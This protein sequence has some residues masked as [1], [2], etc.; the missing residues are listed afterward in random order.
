MMSGLNSSDLEIDLLTNPEKVRSA[1]DMPANMSSSGGGSSYGPTVIAESVDH[2][3]L[4]PPSV[5]ASSSSHHKRALSRVSEEDSSSDSQSSRSRRSRPRRPRSPAYSSA[6]S[7]SSSGAD[8][9]CS[10]GNTTEDDGDHV[11]VRGATVSN[12]AAAGV[13]LGGSS[14][15]KMTPEEVEA[16]KR[17]LLFALYRFQMKNNVQLPRELTLN[18]SLEE[19][20]LAVDFCRREAKLSQAV[21]LSK[22]VLVTVCSGLEFLNEKY[23][24]FDVYL[25]GWSET[26]KENEDEYDDVFEELFEKY[27]DKVA[28]SPEIKLMM[29]V[30]GSAAGYHLMYKG[31]K[32]LSTSGMAQAL[33]TMSGPKNDPPV[34]L[35]Q[36]PPPNARME[37]SMMNAALPPLPPRT[38]APVAQTPMGTM[39]AMGVAGGANGFGRNLAGAASIR[40]GRPPM[41]AP[42]S[43][44]DLLQE[45]QAE[46]MMDAP[47]SPPIAM[48]YSPQMGGSVMSVEL[49]PSAPSGRGRGRGGGA[50]R[51]RA[52]KTSVV[53]E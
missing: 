51:G 30:V 43:I 42:M 53:I 47:A 35:P 12:A 23:D 18:S 19:I 5:R 44:E 29:M 17:K 27:Q 37:P 26:V 20:Q 50:G 15:P 28:V 41:R 33:Q 31:T 34:S 48:P 46:E 11:S 45:A 38:A 32:A 14:K 22:H 7:S 49:P 52:K 24:P 10:Y 13:Q 9:D 21:K 39:T 8:S 1:N 6:S 2:I 3:S 36:A 4:S 40:E 25:T 16:E